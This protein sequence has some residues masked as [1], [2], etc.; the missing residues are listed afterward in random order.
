MIKIALSITVAVLFISCSQSQSTDQNSDGNEANTTE[1]TKQ[2]ADTQTVQPLPDKEVKS[3]KGVIGSWT[4]DAE[5]AGI[6]MDLTFNEDGS[7]IQP[8]AGREIKG[9]WKQKDETHLSMQN[10]K[11]TKPDI[12]EIKGS[13]ENTL[14]I[15]WNPT[16]AK[17]KS[18]PFKRSN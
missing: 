8:M 9:I 3:S 2:N 4:V 1:E 5:T 15:C 6:R 17:P 11:Q 14:N 10:E 13:S 16:S 7:Y 18:I 12:W